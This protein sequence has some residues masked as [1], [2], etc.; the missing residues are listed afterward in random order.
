M[1]WI[2]HILFI[3]LFIVFN[4][5]AQDLD[6]LEKQLKDDTNFSPQN[7]SVEM[8]LKVAIEKG[9]RKNNAQKTRD[10]T[11]EIIELNFQDAFEEFWLPQLNLTIQTDDHYAESLYSDQ[12]ENTLSKTPNGFVGLE[13]EEYT[14]FNWGRDYLNYLNE[15]ATYER[16]KQRLTEQKRF[17]R[18][19]IIDQYFNTKRLKKLQRVYRSQL[20]HTSFMYR[21]NK[22][23]L[24]LKKINKQQYFQAKAEFLRAHKEYQDINAEVA[25]AEQKLAEL[26]GDDLNTTY[27]LS[28]EIKVKPFTLRKEESVN[29]A[30]L[31]SPTIRQAR[32]ELLNSNRDFQRIKKENLPLP[33]FSVRLGA[34][35]NSFSTAGNR[36]TVTT[37]GNNRNVEVAASINMSWRL[38]GSGGIFNSR[39]VERSYFDKRISEIQFTEAKRE[40]STNI[41]IFHKRIKYLEKEIEATKRQRDNN[42]STFDITLDRYIAG[43]T[44][45]PNM[46]L[47]LDA[48]IGAEVNYENA[49]YEHMSERLNLANFIGIDDFPG[50]KF[51]E[52]VLK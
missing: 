29:F 31:R 22:E 26:V 28:N 32:V 45:F 25:Q 6:D 2:T 11:K 7:E 49:K 23:K 30:Q 1:K 44:D 46:K 15:K 13:F 40:V 4:C 14:V 24:Q 48:L 52:M 16:E 8:S 38:F 17:L 19:Q 51:E 21:L 34:Y 9:L 35:R 47:V 41:H 3:N 12:E 43:K 33:K 18:L 42:R 10:Y 20:R 39:D 50:E 36:E 37:N 27:T 5:Y